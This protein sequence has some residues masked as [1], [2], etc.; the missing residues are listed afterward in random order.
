MLEPQLLPVR[1]T[2]A[3]GEYFPA[4]LLRLAVENGRRSVRDLLQALGIAYN[5][6]LTSARL[7]KK[8]APCLDLTADDLQGMIV[9]DEYT[10]RITVHKTHR[11]Y[12]DLNL[13]G[14]RVCTQCLQ[15]GEPMPTYFGWLPF[16]HC[17]KH[18]HE[19]I[20]ACPS[21]Y[22]PFNWSDDVLECRCPSCE[23]SFADA[24]T[25]SV[26]PPYV[27]ELI[28][29]KDDGDA[30]NL[31]VNDLMQ[32]V[33]YVQDPYSGHLE[34]KKRA[35]ETADWPN[36]LDRA[37]ALLSESNPTVWIEMCRSKRSVAGV[38]GSVAVH[39]PIRSLQDRLRLDWPLKNAD[40]LSDYVPSA[41]SQDAERLAPVDE[42]TLADFF[43]CGLSDIH[44]MIEVA[45]AFFPSVE[46]S[47]IEFDIDALTH[48]VA[49]LQP[50]TDY[51]LVSTQQARDIAQWYG[52][53]IGQVLGGV[54]LGSVPIK[55]MPKRE[56]LLDGALFCVESL[57]VFL[58]KLFEQLSGISGSSSYPTAIT[59]FSRNVAASIRRHQQR[60]MPHYQVG[61][62]RYDYT[63]RPLSVPIKSEMPSISHRLSMSAKLL[64]KYK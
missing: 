18:Q 59:L 28:R 14:T 63:G 58:K 35:D 10:S 22:M 39:L 34:L 36:L 50:P 15:A 25:K 45:P 6:T 37:Y 16:T 13:R 43:G 27:H 9:N 57:I 55:L 26:L 53:S 5:N 64:S 24:T 30:L 2:P 33:L 29:I 60:S 19:L 44:H 48:T 21:C 32:A 7:V 23:Q 41:P 49:S 40:Y 47:R 8:L 38:F 11:A 4:Y 31:F 56:A 3:R 1:L 62:H 17:F 61:Q 42:C 12:R 52:C 46:S 54:I 51:K 20:Q